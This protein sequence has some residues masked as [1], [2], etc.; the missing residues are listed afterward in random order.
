MKW[1]LRIIVMVLTIL[2]MG[3]IF[4]MSGFPAAQSSIQSDRVVRM[5]EH[6][7]PAWYESLTEAAQS[8]FAD[9]A[10]FFVR[11]SAHFLEYT[12]LGALLALNLYLW[13]ADK[14]VFPAWLL[15]TLYACSDEF[16]Q[17]FVAGRS[18]EIRDVCIDSSGVLLGCALAAL[19]VRAVRKKTRRSAKQRGQTH[20]EPRRSAKQRGQTVHPG[21]AAQKQAKNQGGKR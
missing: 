9:K 6:W 2:W 14:L 17:T 13:E 18:G 8:R 7:D 20:K 1:T 16:H 5:L 10:S 15:G 11:K 19:L 12:I 3:L 4:R 21:I